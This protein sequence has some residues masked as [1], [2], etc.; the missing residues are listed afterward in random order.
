MLYLNKFMDTVQITLYLFIKKYFTFR[1]R[2]NRSE[3]ISLVILFV[4]LDYTL[5][6]CLRFFYK[7]DSSII[8]FVITGA[9]LFFPMIALMIRRLHDFNKSGWWIFMIFML[10]ESLYLSFQNHPIFLEYIELFMWAMW[11]PILVLALIKGTPGPNRFG[12][13]PEYV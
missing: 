2:S 4:V 5:S 9:I 10:L 11:G 13:E 3:Y 6:L 12:N 1:G 8:E 7:N